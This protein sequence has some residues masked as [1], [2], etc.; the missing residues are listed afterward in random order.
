MSSSLT[1]LRSPLNIAFSTLLLE[2]RFLDIIVQ[3]CSATAPRSLPHIKGISALMAPSTASTPRR[4][5]VR[6]SDA[7]CEATQQA[8]S[9]HIADVST[10]ED[11][12][13]GD[14][15]DDD[16]ELTHPRRI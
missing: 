14:G 16:P 5:L 10:F 1:L 7:L 8:V 9:S 4:G 2:L 13:A 6:K 11:T 12:E 3:H 15:S